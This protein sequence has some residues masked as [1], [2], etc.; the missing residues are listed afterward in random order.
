MEVTLITL[1]VITLDNLMQ[2]STLLARK[3][4]KKVPEYVFLVLPLFSILKNFPAK[5]GSGVSTS[6]D[7]SPILPAQIS[8]LF[9]AV[10]ISVYDG[11]PLWY[12]KL[13]KYLP[14]CAF[15]AR[16]CPWFA[17]IFYFFFLYYIDGLLW[18][19]WTCQVKV[20]FLLSRN[21]TKVLVTQMKQVLASPSLLSQQI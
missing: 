11:E 4:K 21:I 17:F 10:I 18:G 16:M 8:S 20:S 19:T 7:L 13:C 14:P 6:R 1:N 5:M 3:K 9:P 2:M 15:P 12:L